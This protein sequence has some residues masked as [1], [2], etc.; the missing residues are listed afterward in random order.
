MKHAREVGC[1]YFTFNIPISVCKDCGH[2]INAPVQ[3]CPKCGSNR[4]DYYTRI[5][6]FLTSVSNWSEERRIEFE[7]RLFGKNK[8]QHHY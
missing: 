3:T 4:I 8:Y 1:N 5:I 7:Q 6:G 2:V